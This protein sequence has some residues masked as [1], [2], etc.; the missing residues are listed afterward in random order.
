MATDWETTKH[1]HYTTIH[2][3]AVGKEWRH[4]GFRKNVY[5]EY[6]YTRYPAISFF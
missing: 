2:R 6:V 5:S 3:L 1:H 4:E